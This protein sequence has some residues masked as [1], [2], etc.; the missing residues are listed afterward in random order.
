MTGITTLPQEIISLV[1]DYLDRRDRLRLARTC[2]MLYHSLIAQLWKK[3]YIQSN[4]PHFDFSLHGK[5][6]DIPPDRP[7]I[8]NTRLEEH[9]PFVQHLS[10]HGPFHPKYYAIVFPQ[11]H[12][13]GLYLDTS[14]HTPCDDTQATFNHALDMSMRAEQHRRRAELIRLNPTIKEI[15]IQT[16]EPQPTAD[17]WDAISTTLN[18]PTRLYVAG[19]NRIEGETLNSFWKACNL[20]EEIYCW[21]NNMDFTSL[22]SQLSFPR[23]RRI[24]LQS[25]AKFQMGFCTEEQLAWFQQCPYL[26]KL[27]WTFDSYRFPSN[28][29]AEALEQGTWQRLEDLS[30]DNLNQRDDALAATLAHLPALCCFRLRSSGFGHLTF[31]ILRAR[32]FDTIKVLDLTGI[33]SFTSRM[34]L[35]VLQECVHLEDFNGVIINAQE[36]DIEQRPWVCLGLKRLATIIAVDTEASSRKAFEALSKLSKLESLDLGTDVLDVWKL[37]DIVPESTYHLPWNLEH[38]L[39][40]LS[41]LTKLRTVSLLGTIQ[42]LVTDED[43]EWTAENLPALEE[44]EGRFSLDTDRQEKLAGILGR[45]GVLYFDIGRHRTEIY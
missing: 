15:R 16:C 5:R 41:T 28:K 33:L 23:L 21:A 20:F 17:F 40:R 22:L 3:V 19:L 30:L 27:H 9:A 26:T 2:R 7:I 10:F 12:T 34:A 44:V 18:H 35:E 6:V 14:F 11:L 1:A 32:L 39:G 31:A 43:V 13:L 8:T 4:F 37:S 45:R 42:E 25:P 24:S 36:I 29:F 38:G